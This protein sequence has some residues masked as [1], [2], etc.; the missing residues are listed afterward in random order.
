MSTATE[1]V[2]TTC[3]EP[4]PADTGFFRQLL[5][6]PDGLADQCNACTRERHR[7]RQLPPRPR[8]SDTLA[9]VW[10]TAA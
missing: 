2:C 6:N 9:S 8:A 1:K 4:W 7:P 3:R 10:M 5:K